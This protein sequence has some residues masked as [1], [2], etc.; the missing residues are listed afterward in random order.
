MSSTTTNNNSRSS[1]TSSTS[2][3]N[4]EL[5]ELIAE[6]AK[7]RRQLKRMQKD[8]LAAEKLAKSTKPQCLKKVLSENRDITNVL[9]NTR[10]IRSALA[11]SSPLSMSSLAGL[12]LYVQ[13]MISS[14]YI[15]SQH[16]AIN[17][18]GLIKDSYWGEIVKTCG[19]VVDNFMEVTE[20]NRIKNAQKAKDLLVNI[21]MNATG[22]RISSTTNAC[23]FK[24]CVDTFMSF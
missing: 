20:Q 21:A 17:F 6:V 3:S 13:P 24:N 23:I 11:S 1:R 16:V 10:I 9:T 5:D 7:I 15:E 18:L 22:A 12:L 4:H 19:M 14:S 2:S 8:F